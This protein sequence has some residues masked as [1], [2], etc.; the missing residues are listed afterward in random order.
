MLPTLTELALASKKTCYFDM[1]HHY[2]L[3]PTIFTALATLL[4]PRLHI[5]HLERDREEVAASYAAS[6]EGPC[7]TKCKLCISPSQVLVLPQA[8]SCGARSLSPTTHH[9]P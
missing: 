3:H 7:S 2:S 4:G 5:I 6:T 9:P 8:P 1:G